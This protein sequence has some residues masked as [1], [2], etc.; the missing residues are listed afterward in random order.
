MRHAVWIIALSMAGIGLA[1]NSQ[2]TGSLNSE[3]RTSLPW[4]AGM[5]KPATEQDIAMLPARPSPDSRVFVG[6]LSAVKKDGMAAVLVHSP[7]RGD[8]LYVDVNLDGRFEAEERFPLTTNR[9]AQLQTD[10]ALLI[11]L[12]QPCAFQSTTP[13][14]VQV[15][16]QGDR[17]VLMNTSKVLVSGSVKIDGIDRLLQYQLS[18][19]SGVVDPKNGW[20]GIDSNGDGTVDPSVFSPESAT[21]DGE[22]IVFRVGSAFVSTETVDLKARKVVLRSHPAS[23]YE[24]I[25]LVAGSVVPDFSFTDATGKVRRLQEFR[26]KYLLL[27]FWAS[28]CG[29]CVADMPKLK[30]VYDRF[31]PGGFEILGMNNDDD[32]AIKKANAIIRDK[33]AIWTHAMGSAARTIIR[34]RFR[35]VPFPTKILLDKEGRIVSIQQEPL[36]LDSGNLANTLEK[37]GL[38]QLAE[39]L[40]H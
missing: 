4:L 1:A 30:Q 23:D 29:P 17:W 19:S 20:Q 24:R 36:P 22:S 40:L 35:I 8:Y 6:K 27:D 15:T 34:K 18:C 33:A 28:W 21:A 37:C 32:E 13:V 9:Q 7:D 3:L 31:S 39:V 25:E 14:S 26:G 38:H 16:A 10:Q 5:M 12:Q 11:Q 2:Y